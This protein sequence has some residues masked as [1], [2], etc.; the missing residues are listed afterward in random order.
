MARLTTSDPHRPGWR[1]VRC[2][3]GFRYRDEAGA[4]LCDDDALARLK[5]LAIPPAW[6]DVWICPRPDGHIQ[7]V[8]TDAAG[9]RQYLYHPDFRA[10]QEAAKHDHVLAV[11]EALPGLRER[12]AAD[13]ALRG[14][15]HDRVAAC[16]ARLLDLGFFRIGS[17]AYAK[18]NGSYGLTTLRRDQAAVR[19]S[20]LCFGYPAKSGRRRDL[21]V[22]DE[23][24]A[25]VV[26]ALL[27]RK[28][29]DPGLWAF[30]E[31]RAWQPLDAADLNAYL[32]AGCGTEVSAKDFRTW[33]ATVL[34]A[35]GLAVSWPQ[36]SG[37]RSARRRAAARVVR[38]TAAYLGN[39]PAVC[40]ASYVNPRLFELYDRGRT[41]AVDLP[42]LAADPE[43]PGLPGIGAGVERA[44][45]DLLSRAND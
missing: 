30:W 32:R 34:V 42:G 1:R 23:C 22:T 43:G 2:G 44:V 25:K 15:Q 24:A 9:R 5:G 20:R 12:V 14:L 35:V 37:S 41:V 4:T 29:A 33:H 10:R 38:E 19:G 28:D 40:R 17:P 13:L 3:R 7:A 26:R 36:A 16:A 39:T 8:G 27:H 11:A 45:L 6:T 18:A 31:H 21:A